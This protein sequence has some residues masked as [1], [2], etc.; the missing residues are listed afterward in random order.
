MSDI[1]LCNNK[2]CVAFK[3]KTCY[4]GAKFQQ[5]LDDGWSGYKSMIKGK[6][7]EKREC[8]LFLPLKEK[9]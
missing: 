2:K 5:L 8:E 7:D 6:G 4:R 1:G 9:V 3:N